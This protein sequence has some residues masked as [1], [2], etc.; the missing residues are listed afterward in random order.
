MP[1]STTKTEELF[2]KNRSGRLMKIQD[3]EFNRFQFDIW[4]EYTRQSMIHLKEG[5]LLA[6]KNFASD[7]F[8]THYSILELTSIKPI[9]YALGNSVDGYPG[10][11]MEAAKNISSDWTNQESESLE[12]TTIIQCTAT[13]T[14][15]EIVRDDKKW[16]LDSDT[17]IPMIGT[18]VKVITAALTKKIVNRDFSEKDMNVIEAGKWLVDRKTPILIKNDDFIRV[19]FGIFGFTKAGKSNLLSSY[20]SKLLDAS[21]QGSLGEDPDK[22]P[23]KIVIFDLMNEYNVLLIDQLMKIEDSILLALGPR[24]FP[25][26]V[27]DYISNKQKDKEIAVKDFLNTSLYPQHFE[28]NKSDFKSFV[29]ALFEKSKIRI[30]QEPLTSDN[31]FID[32]VQFLLN[33]GADKESKVAFLKFIDN[34]KNARKPIN[35]EFISELLNAVDSLINLNVSGDYLHDVPLP[36]KG[37]GTH[38]STNLNKVRSYLRNEKYNRS[39]VFPEKATIKMDDLLKILNDG[40][41]SSLVIIQSHDPD[42]LREFASDIGTAIFEDRRKTGKISPLISFIFDEADEFIPQTPEK[43]TTQGLSVKIVEM[44]A[45]RGRKFGIGIGI[46][47]QRTRYL[48]TSIM[49]QPH[50]YLISKLP[51]KTDRDAVQEAF[52]FSD[53]IFRQTFKFTKGDWLLISYDATG[54]T[55]VPIPIH[56]DDANKRIEK[57]IKDTH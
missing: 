1:D 12:D 10:F 5:T 26:S 19:H 23:I 37:W 43:D 42:D 27:I 39:N 17:S 14:E 21:K 38:A 55:G 45:R 6:A 7:D 25:K 15:I 36:K 54:L 49:A 30:F 3:N 22:K 24:T 32:K 20:I 56:A 40:T 18:E 13:P 50:T 29:Q 52:G 46:A 9:H 28:N 4:F 57:A 48:K 8:S 35:I 41:R 31:E 33:I 2:E 11:V 16:D 53:E 34:V 44:L 51:R 47:T